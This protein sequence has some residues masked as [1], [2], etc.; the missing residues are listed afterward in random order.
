MAAVKNTKP[1]DRTSLSQELSLTREI[2]KA[3]ASVEEG[4]T[5]QG[6]RF[7]R[8]NG[9]KLE[10]EDVRREYADKGARPGEVKADRREPGVWYF[11]F[12]YQ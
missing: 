6:T 9:T 3:R 5:R 2:P 8:V 12:N 1:A 4:T 10:A 7:V 11:Y